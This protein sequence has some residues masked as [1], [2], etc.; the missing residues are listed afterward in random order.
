MGWLCGTTDGDR[1]EGTRL[2]LFPP[3][4]C[5]FLAGE[6]IFHKPLEKFL[7]TEL[8]GHLSLPVARPGVQT[9]LGFP[10]SFPLTPKVPCAPLNPG[11]D[12]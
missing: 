1:K 8:V 4:E 10:H 12:G 9:D 3:Y 2:P 11:L 6:N 5:G 7:H